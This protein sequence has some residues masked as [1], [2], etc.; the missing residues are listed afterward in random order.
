MG[1]FT[2]AFPLWVSGQS[3]VTI[4]SV[5]A[6]NW[7]GSP[8][9]C[10]DLIG[11][12][13]LVVAASGP[14]GKKGHERHKLTL[15]A[16]AGPSTMSERATALGHGQHECHDCGLFQSVGG[17]RPGQ[18]A[19][20]RR[21]GAVLRRRRRNSLSTMMAL[22]AAGLCLMAVAETTPIAS[23][24]PRRA[25][26]CDNA[27]P[28]PGRVRRAGDAGARGAGDGDD[29]PRAAPS[30]HP[31]A[32]GYGRLAAGNAARPAGGDGAGAEGIGPMGHDRGCFLLGFMVAYSRLGAIATV[33]TG[34]GLYALAGLMLVTAWSDTWLDEDAMWDAIRPGAGR[35]GGHRGSR[36]AAPRRPAARLRRLRPRQPWRGR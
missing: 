8:V 36:S 35:T 30:R 14:H 13:G 15:I 4:G 33:S 27:H 28:P 19:E 18:V 29:D 34:V 20:C 26:A 25:G 11:R 2:C 22:A 24:R 5:N 6:R 21:C 23:I 3:G 10:I 7:A 17:L 9:H 12:S 16:S 32:R 31:D 1:A